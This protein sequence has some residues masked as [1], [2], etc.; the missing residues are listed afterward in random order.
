MG[1]SYNHR[2]HR[3]NLIH[4]NTIG[5]LRDDTDLVQAGV[6]LAISEGTPDRIFIRGLS[7][8]PVPIASFH[9]GSIDS[10]LSDSIP[11]RGSPESVLFI[12]KGVGTPME[13]SPD[14]KER[15]MDGPSVPKLR[16]NKIQK[17]DDVWG[18][19]SS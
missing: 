15:K 2:W 7:I 10:R 13:A 1:R 6:K 5:Q 18:G 11:A 9:I 16:Q 4:F 12:R 3:A 14:Q 19:F 8:P 17:F